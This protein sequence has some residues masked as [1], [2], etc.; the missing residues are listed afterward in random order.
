MLKLILF[1][2]V[3]MTSFSHAYLGP[4]MGGGILAATIGIIVAIFGIF[5]GVLWFPIKRFFRNKKKKKENK[6]N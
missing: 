1:F 2:F 5:F 6:K 3:S 4:G